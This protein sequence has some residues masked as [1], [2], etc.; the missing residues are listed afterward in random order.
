M[1]CAM[2]AHVL[3]TEFD[4][5]APATASPRVIEDVIRRDIGFDGLLFSDDIGMAALSGTTGERCAAMLAAG[6]DVVLECSG[7]IEVML[8][9]ADAA[10][11]LTDAASARLERA[12]GEIGPP[13]EIDVA[14]STARLTALID[15]TTV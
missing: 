12:L 2:A 1:A 9:T 4:A 6:C 15:A 14:Q 8:A 13:D 10:S 11:P 3:Y 5:T 7:D